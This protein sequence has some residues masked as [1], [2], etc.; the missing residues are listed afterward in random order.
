MSDIQKELALSTQTPTRLTTGLPGFDKV[1]QGGLIRCDSYVV[2]GAPGTGKTILANQVAFN[3]IAGGGRVVFPTV[4]T[5]SHSRMIVHLRSLSF[6]NP[7]VV[8]DALYYISGYG[9]LQREG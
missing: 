2:I 7:D 3:H 5:E 4:L 9:I 1:L 8:G 6:F